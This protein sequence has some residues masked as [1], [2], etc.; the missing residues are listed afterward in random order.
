MPNQDFFPRLE[1]EHEGSE[2]CIADRIALLYIYLPQIHWEIG[3]FIRVWN[4]HTIRAQRNRP[5][6][7]PGI[8]RDNFFGR[9]TPVKVN[10]AVPLDPD[11]LGRLDEALEYDRQ[12]VAAYLSPDIMM[13]CEAMMATLD[14]DAIPPR[15][16]GSPLITEYRH[17]RDCLQNHEVQQVS[18]LLCL[19]EKPTGGWPALDAVVQQTGRSLEDILGEDIVDGF[20]AGIDA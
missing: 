1:R 11:S 8:T 6:V 7:L 13:L 15:V 9:D 18:P 19:A 5:H 12:N 3:T 17:L 14:V 10:C 16:H 4:G 2:Y 20:D